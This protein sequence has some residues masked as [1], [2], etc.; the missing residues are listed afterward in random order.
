MERQKES[1]PEFWCLTGPEC[2]QKGVIV[3]G[4]KRFLGWNYSGSQGT[5]MLGRYPLPPPPGFRFQ[6]RQENG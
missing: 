4:D 2:G 3:G 6:L 5:E 1:K